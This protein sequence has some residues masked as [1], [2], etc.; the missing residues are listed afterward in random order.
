MAGTTDAEPA[1]I[2]SFGLTW[3][4]TRIPRWAY[5]ILVLIVAI[6]VL[7]ALIGKPI[8]QAVVT[9]L[10]VGSIYVLGASGLSL[11]YGIKKFANFAHGDLMTVGAYAAFYVN[12]TLAQNI[13]FGVAYAILVV[14]ILG[15]LL[16]L[17]IFRRLEGTSRSGARAFRS[18]SSSRASLSSWPSS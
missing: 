13:Y 8:L 1:A 3:L 4:L 7:W 14:A 16:E 12:V 6:A 11:T 15:V 17:S 10:A 9:G 5:A 18:T 2:P